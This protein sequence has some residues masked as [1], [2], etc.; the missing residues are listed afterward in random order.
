MTSA[1]RH[2]SCFCVLAPLIAFAGA[3]HAQ[4]TVTCP[5]TTTIQSAKVETGNAAGLVPYVTNSTI[6]LT[7]VSVFDGPP[8][9]GAALIPST[10]AA[11][12]S[13]I[14]WNLSE[15]HVRE[16][17]VSCDYAEGAVRLARKVGSATATCVA[18]IQASSPDRAFGA[19]FECK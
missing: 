16:G 8:N 3:C 18:V 7:G 10:V 5:K 13:R 1:I 4:E 6:R 9:E 17:W 2:P 11:K 12:G 15:A 14:S 19:R